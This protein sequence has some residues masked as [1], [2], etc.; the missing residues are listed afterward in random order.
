M[1]KNTSTGGT[2]RPSNSH[3]IGS[4]LQNSVPSSL[5]TPPPPKTPKK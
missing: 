1:S 3:E 5:K 4:K 2:K